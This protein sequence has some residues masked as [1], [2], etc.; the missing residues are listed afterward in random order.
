MTKMTK[1][2]EFNDKH[3]CKEDISKIAELIKGAPRYFIQN[4]VDSGNVIKDGLHGLDNDELEEFKLC[5][6]Q[7][8]VDTNIRG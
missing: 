2:Y 8:I 3:Y 1:V 5:A 4:F 6:R 7:H